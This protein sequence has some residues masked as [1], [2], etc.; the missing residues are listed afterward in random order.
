MIEYIRLYGRKVEI[1][2]N[3]RI[4]K[5]FYFKFR[6]QI[7]VFLEKESIMSRNWQQFSILEMFRQRVPLS[8]TIL[9]LDLSETAWTPVW[10]WEENSQSV[11]SSFHSL[12][13]ARWDCWTKEWTRSFTTIRTTTSQTLGRVIISKDFDLCTFYSLLSLLKSPLSWI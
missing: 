4:S 13:R 2:N 7:T 5:L 1:I 10:R 3:S 11:F 12:S 6:C 8:L 9:I